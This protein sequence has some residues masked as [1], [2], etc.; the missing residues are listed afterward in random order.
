MYLIDIITSCRAVVLNLT[1]ITC[2]D[3]ILRYCA[4]CKETTID[5]RDC[6]ENKK[7]PAIVSVSI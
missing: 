1:V 4:H 7:G 2:T 3:L 6:L 5:D